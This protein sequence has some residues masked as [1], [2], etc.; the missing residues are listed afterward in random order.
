MSLKHPLRVPGTI[1]CAIDHMWVKVITNGMNLSV[2]FARMMPFER[3]S[4][5]G[6]DTRGTS[7]ETI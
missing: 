5:R 4:G 1:L 6:I 7:F 3:L 2:Q